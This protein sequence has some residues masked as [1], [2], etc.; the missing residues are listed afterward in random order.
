MAKRATGEMSVLEHIAD[1]RS[2]LLW[3]MGLALAAATGAWF[4]SETIVEVLFLPVIEGGAE[5]LYFRG[6]MDAFLIRMKAAFVVGLFLVLPL[7]LYKIYSFVM[8]GLHAAERRVVTP[9]LF[10]ATALFYVGVAFCFL[11]L[12]P[13]VVRFGLSWSTSYMQPLLEVD[14][15]FGFAARLCMAFGLLFELPMVVFVLAWVGVVKPMTLL[16]GWRYALV[17]IL[18]VAAVL[19]PPDLVSQVL[20]AGPVMVLYIASVLVAMLVRRKRK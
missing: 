4:F 11:V 3:A 16:K 5:S 12:L 6:P 1:L 7:I 15:Y 17:S 13:L 20:L 19:T 18:A 8:P 9:M 2:T 10:A 14:R